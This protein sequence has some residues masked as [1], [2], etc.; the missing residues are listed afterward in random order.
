MQFY[1]EAENNE[2]Q[3]PTFFSR[4]HIESSTPFLVLEEVEHHLASVSC[5]DSKIELQFATRESYDNAGEVCSNLTGSYVITSHAECN[6]EGARMP[7][8]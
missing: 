7:F 5:H 4:V 1:H 6:D 2:V 8:L 3:G